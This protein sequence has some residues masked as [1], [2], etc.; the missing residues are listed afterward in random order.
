MKKGKIFYGWWI[1]LG[2]VIMLAVMGPASVAVANLYQGPVTEDFG[3]PKSMFAIVNTIVLGVGIFLAPFV[4][5]QLSK[6]GNF[7]RFLTIG[8]VVY[9]LAYMGYGFA[10][11][12][13]TFYILSLLVGFGYVSTTVIPSS[14][15]VSNWFVEKRGSAIS[16]ALTG[17]GIG[18][19]VFS[20]LL[21]Y[22]IENVGWRQTYLI[23]GI[24]MLVVCLPITWLL[25]K[26][27]PEELGL[28]PLG[29]N[30]QGHSQQLKQK[31]A[32]GVST[33][34]QQTIKAPFFLLLMSGA[35]LIGIINN[36]GLG[37]FPPYLNAIHGA[38]KGAAIV[39]IYSAVGIAGKIILGNLNDKYGVVKSTI[40]ATA[41]LVL[42]YSLMPLGDDYSI[43]IIA[44][45]LFGL[46]NAVGTVA[47]P[48]ITSAIYAPTNYSRAY[49]FVQSAVQLGMTLGSLVAATIADISSY[50]TAWIVMAIISALAGLIWVSAVATA[51]QF[52]AVN[53]KL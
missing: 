46:G 44:A 17:L 28:Q 49:G 24:I 22:L 53:P 42:T 48:L 30:N 4:A 25:M 50:G 9:A 47:P 36:G 39:S 23:Y 11:N 27:R 40:Y 21:T 37:Q 15:I 5:Q 16:L 13:Y 1:V 35:V 38:V 34:F 33:P 29:A 43:A 19:V 10:Q 51:K 12:I 3:I 41:L 45:I 7:K 14:I 2:S 26:E 8:I 52:S 6:Q 31:T 18:G 32:T 20:Q